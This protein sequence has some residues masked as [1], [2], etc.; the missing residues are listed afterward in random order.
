MDRWHSRAWPALLGLFVLV[1]FAGVASAHG[2]RTVSTPIPGDLLLAGAAVTVGGTAGALA[3]LDASPS[4]AERAVAAVPASRGRLLLWLLRLCLLA[5]VV[6]AIVEGVTGRQA[7]VSPATT[8]VWP[9]WVKG[10]LLLAALVG[11]HWTALAPWTTGYEL[12]SRLEGRDVALFDYPG[13]LGRWPAAVG[14]V[15]V[16]GV[17][18]NL[19]VIPTR[20][21][22]T[23]T[24]VAVYA[25]VM[26]LGAVGFGRPWLRNADP[27]GV[28]YGLVG[29]VAPLSVEHD[30]DR[31]AFVVT[32]RPIWHEA[33]TPLPDV[34][35][36]ALAVS[37]V[38]TVSFDG[39][40][41]TG[42]YQRLLFD[43]TDT[44]LGPV[45]GLA[46]YLGGLVLFLA[47]FA[48]VSVLAAR[49]GGAGVGGVTR[50]FGATLLPIAVAY[51]VAHNWPYVLVNVAAL[52]RL[53]APGIPSVAPSPVVYWGSAVG[54]VVLGH[55]VAVVAT[56]LVSRELFGSGAARGHAPL[57]ALMVGYTVLSLW[58]LSRPVGG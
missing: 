58:I 54:L 47:L 22:L 23:A 5:A 21:R 35:S 39:I 7:R 32:R 1:S 28:L 4:R 38:Y 44:A 11:N 3:R 10:S 2:V 14:F 24:L 15:L 6:A 34:A 49:L 48:A 26:L 51:D 41:E 55:L 13:W 42:S 37:A 31:D 33:A 19:T 56:H 12:L 25:L 9:V 40:V 18:E 16:V 46:T 36:V 43:L 20:P 57:V 30:R 8:F 50:W 29:R 45:A 17:V 53:A 52:G 27:L